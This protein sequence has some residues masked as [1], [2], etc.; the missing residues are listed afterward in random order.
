M[1]E[2]LAVARLGADENVKVECSI[3]KNELHKFGV[4]SPVITAATMDELMELVKVNDGH[5]GKIVKM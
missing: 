1:R 4:I 2:F 5:T 3:P